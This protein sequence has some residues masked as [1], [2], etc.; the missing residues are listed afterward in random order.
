ML[1]LQFSIFPKL[2]LPSLCLIGFIISYNWLAHC[3]PSFVLFLKRDTLYIL[4]PGRLGKGRPKTDG[5]TP[6]GKP[7]E[8]RCRA[9]SGRKY[10]IYFFMTDRD[11]RWGMSVALG[12]AFLVHSLF[13]HLGP[14]LVVVEGEAEHTR[15]EMMIFWG[16]CGLF[17][18][19]FLCKSS[20]RFKCQ[21]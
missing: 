16:F 7:A 9:V 21:S 12:K 13:I 5:R 15:H 1:H 3:L 17:M 20:S 4:G 2:H 8:P 10:V 14:H 19:A 6:K 18:N 11:L